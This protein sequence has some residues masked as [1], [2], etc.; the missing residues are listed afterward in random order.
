MLRHSVA[1]LFFLLSSSSE[2]PHLHC[3]GDKPTFWVL[4]L[5]VA[6]HSAS[7][8]SAGDEESRV[9][10]ANSQWRKQSFFLL[11]F[12]YSP[13]LYPGNSSVLPPAWLLTRGAALI[14][15]PTKSRCES[16]HLRQSSSV[17]CI[18]CCSSASSFSTLFL[19]F[20]PA[21]PRP[22]PSWQCAHASHFARIQSTAANRIQKVDGFSPPTITVNRYLSGCYQTTAHL[23]RRALKISVYSIWSG[24]YCVKSTINNDDESPCVFLNVPIRQTFAEQIGSIIKQGWWIFRAGP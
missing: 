17:N 1:F 10:Q 2:G 15:I 3:G 20:S 4:A 14:I 12:I 11:L 19:F 16:T 23:R 9:K 18:R 22:S 5:N 21:R 6:I 7:Q 8:Q 13:P 24:D